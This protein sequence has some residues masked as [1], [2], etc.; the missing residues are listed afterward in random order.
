MKLKFD[1][2]NKWY[3]HIPASILKIWDAQTPLGF[4]DTN[5][6]PY[7]GQTTRPNNNQ[8]QQSENTQK[9]KMGRKTTVWTFQKTNKRN[10]TRDNLDITKKGKPLQRKW[11]SSNSNTE[12]RHKDYVKAKIDKTQQNSWGRLSG[13]R[14]ET[15]NPLISE[16]CKL[17]QKE[18]KIRHDWVGKMI[19]LGLCKKLKFDH[20]NKW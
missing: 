16:W 14:D 18:C 15:I 10:P 13:E 6:S 3:M 9:T 17:A 12:Q 7:L 8:Q 19:H 1:L 4:C 5:G 11:M 2:T 20:K